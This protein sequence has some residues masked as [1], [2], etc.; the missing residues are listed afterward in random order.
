MRLK[1][2]RTDFGW[3]S[4]GLHWTGAILVL[5][6]LFIGNSIRSPETAMQSNM[7]RLHTTLA[8][9]F[10][11]LLWARVVWRFRVGHPAPLPKQK[12][13]TY[14]VGAWFHY[15]LLMALG[16]MLVSGPLMAWAGDLPLRVW[17][18]RIRSPFG[19][20]PA[21]FPAMRAVHVAAATVLGWG[22]LLHLLAVLK[23]TVID[24]DGSF[25]KIMEPMKQPAPPDEEEAG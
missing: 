16:A 22:T 23:H 7:L 14:A 25:D 12:P 4:I 10:Y 13:F 8:L 19:A 9:V 2:G 20:S 18:L 21:L 11:V 1:D 15:V 3:I 17:D 24:R 5:A 6:L